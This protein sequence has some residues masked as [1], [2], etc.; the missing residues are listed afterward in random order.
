M[1]KVTR[2]SV[3]KKK[4]PSLSFSNV[5]LLPFMPLARMAATKVLLTLK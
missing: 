4:N 5:Y 1:A 3:G 2:H